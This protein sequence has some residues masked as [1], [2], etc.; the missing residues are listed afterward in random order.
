MRM[1]R[2]RRAS[3]GSPSAR[4]RR[5]T[6]VTYR[7]PEDTTQNYHVEGLPFG[8]RGGL[9]IDHTFPADG[10]Y[11]FKVFSVNLG[12]MGNF[13]P[14]GEIKGEKL[15]VYLDD[16]R[17]AT[18]RL[19]QGAGGEQAASTRRAAASCKT[20]DVSCRSPPGC[21]ISA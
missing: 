11:T 20:I 2:R 17:V 16:K 21:T 8:T 9:R 13:R 3:A 6:Q 18:G 14:F 10:T 12:N 15:L 5:P 7:V 19:G 1:S 4:R